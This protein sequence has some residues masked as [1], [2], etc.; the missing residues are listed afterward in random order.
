MKLLRVFVNKKI[1][2]LLIKDMFLQLFDLEQLR[3]D[4][5]H[6]IATIIQKSWRGFYLWKK[7]QIMRKAQIMLSKNIK[8]Y[9]VAFY[10][11]RKPIALFEKFEGFL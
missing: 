2:P 8:K 7:F 9:Q 11:R 1:S 3:S 10:F 4:K 6:D 5:L